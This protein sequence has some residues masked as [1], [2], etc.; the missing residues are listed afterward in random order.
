MRREDGLCPVCM[1]PIPEDNW[2]HILDAG[3]NELWTIG[4]M[5]LPMEA[6]TEQ[7]QVLRCNGVCA[8]CFYK[9]E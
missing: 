1:L 8:G 7:E 4:D 6:S 5:D 3:L 2:E 9:L